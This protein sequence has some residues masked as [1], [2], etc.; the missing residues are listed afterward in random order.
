MDPERAARYRQY[1]EDTLLVA[2]SALT[3]TDRIELCEIADWWGRE[4]EKAAVTPP[5]LQ[6]QR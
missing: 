5:R 6:A 2:S 4:A 3:E 1:A